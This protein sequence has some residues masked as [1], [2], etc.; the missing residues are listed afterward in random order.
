MS[1]HESC[2]RL[3]NKG[4]VVYIMLNDRIRS[5]RANWEYV[6]SPRA[7]AGHDSLRTRVAARWKDVDGDEYGSLKKS[8][9]YHGFR[10]IEWAYI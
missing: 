4:V 5:V 7:R 3:G 1:V 8:V 6:S 2:R 9:S 10:L